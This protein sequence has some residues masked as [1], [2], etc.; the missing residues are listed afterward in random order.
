MERGNISLY[1]LFGP[2]SQEIISKRS[3]K[4]ETVTAEST[5][6]FFIF[7]LFFFISVLEQNFKTVSLLKIVRKFTLSTRAS[8]ENNDG[9]TVTY[10]GD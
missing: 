1:S 10:E 6:T 7:F 2:G 3:E 5:S 9:K 8:S 4:R